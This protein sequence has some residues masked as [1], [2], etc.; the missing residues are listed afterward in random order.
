MCTNMD[1]FIRATD[2]QYDL[3]AQLDKLRRFAATRDTKVYAR[4]G[5]K[6]DYVLFTGGE[7]TLHPDFLRLMLEFRK[8][9]PRLPFCLLTNGRTLA[10]PYFA[11]RLLTAV[12]APFSVAIAVH[13][14]DAKTHDAVTRSP[15][16]F[17]QTIAGLR[18]VFRYRRP[19]QEI[20]I[21][22]VL[23]KRTAQ[24]LEPTL[25][26][27]LKAFPDARLYRLSL[28]HLEMEGQAERNFESIRLSLG[29]C[30]AH[31]EDSL[32]TLGRFHD[33]RLYHFPLCVLPPGL[34][35]RARRTLPKSDVRFLRKCRSCCVRKSCAGVQR[36]YPARFGD[37]EF[38]PIGGICAKSP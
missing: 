18:N 34:R 6:T 3:E 21:R 33:F 26:Y 13:G 31:I 19:G 38:A 14:H 12:G 24:H 22:I 9:L 16:S 37:S 23:H 11:R 2:R 1:S 35:A 8:A 5:E 7:P 25:D 28:I 32:E 27:L 4:N 20:E 29:D 17:A 30:V 10:Y 15:G 36:W